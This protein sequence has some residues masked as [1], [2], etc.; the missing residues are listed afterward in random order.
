MLRFSLPPTAARDRT[1]VLSFKMHQ[2]WRIP[3]SGPLV[4]L[5]SGNQDPCFPWQV[6]IRTPPFPGKWQSGRLLSLASG[7]QDPSFPWQV[8]IRTPPFPGKWQSGPL[9]SLA[10]AIRTPAF[11]GKWQSGPHLSLA[12]GNQAPSFP[13]Q[14]ALSLCQGK[15]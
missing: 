10:S 8:A 13:W 9:F 2:G 11:P 5:A 4:S 15:A 1:F 3:E 7:N 6:A 12:S 14:V